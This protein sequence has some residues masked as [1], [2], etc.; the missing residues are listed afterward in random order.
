MPGRPSYGGVVLRGD[1]LLVITPAGKPVT[2][3]AEGRD[4][5]RRDA[6]AGR[7]RARCARRRASRSTVAR[8]ARR[9]L[10]TPTGAAAG[11]CARPSTSSSA[12]SSTG[13]TADHDHEVDDARWIPLEQAPRGAQLPGRAG[14][15]RA[16]AVQDAPS[17]PLV[18]RRR[19]GPQLLLHGLR[20][21]DEARSQDR[22]DPA[23]RQAAQVPQE[24]GRARHRR[25]PVLAAREAL[26][27]GDRQRR[28][29]AGQGPLPARH[30]ARQP[31]V[32]PYGGA[33]ALPQADLRPRGRRWRTRSRS[34]ASRRSSRTRRTSR[35]A[36][37]ASAAPRT[38]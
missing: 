10:A 14:A 25:L 18:C 28:G 20:R 13:S 15:D 27:R 8:A 36:C 3:A 5:G 37:A 34:C 35:T 9:R 2:G 6:R 33:R 11:G 1:E 31:R 21:P 17:R 23:R 22:D 12:S 7:R 29:Q 26:P 4:G 30:R 32:P 38:S 16:R 24:P 19:A